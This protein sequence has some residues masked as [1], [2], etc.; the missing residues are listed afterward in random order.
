MAQRRLTDMLKIH[1]NLT[2]LSMMQRS[3]FEAVINI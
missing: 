2:R 1:H 3:P